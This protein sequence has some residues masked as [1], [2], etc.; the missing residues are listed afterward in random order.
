MKRNYL[1][2]LFFVFA[3]FA[4]VACGGDDAVTDDGENGDGDGSVL[5][6][7]FDFV[8][9]EGTGKVTFTNKSTN[10]T[11]YEW[12]FGD[13]DEGF[14]SEKNPVYTYAKGGNY[15]VTLTALDAKGNYKDKTRTVEVALSK[16]EISI[17]IDNEFDDWENIPW[18]DDITLDGG[19]KKIKTAA[20]NNTLYVHLRGD[21]ELY[22]TARKI[23]AALDLDYNLDTGFPESRYKDG[24]SGAD[25]MQEIAG[26]H[27]WGWRAE[28][29]K[30]GWDWIKDGWIE[31]VSKVVGD[32]ICMEWK[33]D[34]TYART[35]VLT[36]N[37][38]FQV[39]SIS[40][41]SQFATTVS[42][43]YIRMY[44]WLRD[45]SWAYVGQAPVPGEVPF[46]IKLNEYVEKEK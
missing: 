42:D 9:E 26:F 24:K 23:T 1:K 46:T 12:E 14:S 5:T 34:L 18:R 27:V 2:G 17:T 40:D 15:S 21:K 19:L 29:Q 44:I 16:P 32:E 6:A 39:P 20:T 7:D 31:W 22:T 37:E 41:F 13:E 11:E 33:L 30:I 38:V 10:A 43:E 25:A 3:T 28:Q 35:Q 8:V 36:N 4:L 45:D